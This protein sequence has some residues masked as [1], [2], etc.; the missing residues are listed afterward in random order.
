VERFDR[1]LQNEAVK[2]AET[3][4]DRMTE[5]LARRNTAQRIDRKTYIQLD[6]LHRILVPMYVSFLAEQYLIVR[7]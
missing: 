1:L 4:A 6:V 3:F 5:E 7:E 2:M